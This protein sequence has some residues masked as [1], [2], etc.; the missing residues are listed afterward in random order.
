MTRVVHD[1]EFQLNDGRDPPPRPELAAKTIGLGTPP[2]QLGQAG[3]LLGREPTACSRWR[4]V[5]EGVRS[6]LAGAFHPLTD[7]PLADPQRLGDLPLGPALLFEAP[8]LEPSGFFPVVRYGF[9][10]G[11][12][13]TEPPDL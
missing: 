13:I 4:A 7:G 1:T 6:R 12:S 3:Q 8:G 5:S 2:Q 11:Q 10:I 9:H